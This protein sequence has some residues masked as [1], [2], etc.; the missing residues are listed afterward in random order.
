MSCMSVMHSLSLNNITHQFGAIRALDRVSLTFRS[1][2]IH[3]VMGENGAGK[4]TL[5]RILAGL[6]RPADGTMTLD[7]SELPLGDP[8]CGRAVGLRFIHQELQAARGLSVAENM[9]LDHPYPCIGP[10]VNWPALNSAAGAALKRLGLDRINPRAAMATLGIGDQMLVRIAGTLI[11]SAERT[12]WL[13]VMDE[14]TAALTSEESERVFAV[15][16]ELVNEGAGVLYVSHRIPEV[17]RLADRITVLRDGAH[18]ATRCRNEADE[19]QVIGDMTGRDLSHLFPPRSGVRS[20]G[21][22]VLQVARL[23]AGP[24]SDAGFDLH[25]G[26]ILG[27]AGLAGSG[28]GALLQALIGAI[29]RHRGQIRLNGRR[30]DHRTARVWAEGLAYIPRERRAEGL[31]L[32]R[33]IVENV[34]LPH[35]ANLS[36][37]RVILRHRKQRSLAASYSQHVRV[38]HA[39]VLQSCDELSGGN[40]QK[41]L[42]A[43]A[44]AGKPQVLL[45]DEPTRGVDI[46]ARHELYRLIRQLS[47]EGRAVMIASSDLPELLGLADRIAIMRD[48]TLAEIVMTE[49]MHEADLLSRF[50]H[51]QP[52]EAAA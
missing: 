36:W 20:V 49:G 47:D 4:S 9:H 32:Q 22:S 29:P 43:R 37:G 3:A 5:I 8:A 1:G 24:V 41:V 23:A 14:P 40:Q 18:V 15:I 2:E 34:V 16:N 46:G 28:R 17:F 10:F 6:L 45:L 7:S 13:Y 39:S 11:G 25:A 35:L 26:E 27:V 50:Y 44:M 33:T 31:L 38:K 42:F 52:K 19:G 12:P 48:G 30:L 21:K 51:L